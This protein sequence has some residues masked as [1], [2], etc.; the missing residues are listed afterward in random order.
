MMSSSPSSK[1]EVRTKVKELMELKT[2]GRVGTCRV[3]IITKYSLMKPN[4]KHLVVV[5]KTNQ[6]S[7]NH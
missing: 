6:I 1:K 2:S 3:L 5:L 4:V 7:A